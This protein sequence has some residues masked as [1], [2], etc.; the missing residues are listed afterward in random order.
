MLR[1]LV[2][3]FLVSY[4]S[5][6]ECPKAAEPAWAL[7]SNN[8]VTQVRVISWKRYIKLYNT[9]TDSIKSAFLGFKVGLRSVSTTNWLFCLVLHI[10]KKNGVVYTI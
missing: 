9:Y 7:F 10:C 4:V 6:Y 2:W 1:H 8:L 3:I 5:D